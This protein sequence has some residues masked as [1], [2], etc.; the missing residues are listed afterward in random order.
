V[1]IQIIKPSIDGKKAEGKV[2]GLVKR[3]EKVL[4]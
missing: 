4:V 3:T 1:K 2:I